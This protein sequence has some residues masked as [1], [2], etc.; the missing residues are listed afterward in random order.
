[1]IF[2]NTEKIFKKDREKKRGT[3][4]DQEGFPDSALVVLPITK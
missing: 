3:A 2:K 4:F 1:M